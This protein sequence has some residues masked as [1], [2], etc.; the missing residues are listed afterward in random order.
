MLDKSVGKIKNIK[1]DSET[2]DMEIVIFITDNKF[3]KKL[4]RDLSLS[5]KIKFK[6]DEILFTSNISDSIDG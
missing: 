2:N 3:K 5:G 1:Y 6:G 4:L